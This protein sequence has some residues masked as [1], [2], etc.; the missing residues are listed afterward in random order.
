MIQFVRML[1]EYFF[2]QSHSSP[3]SSE[4]FLSKRERDIRI[5]WLMP[6][7]NI[8]VG[9]LLLLYLMYNGVFTP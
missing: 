2:P 5:D 8:L 9:S 6:V 7:I 4:L 1:F 3:T